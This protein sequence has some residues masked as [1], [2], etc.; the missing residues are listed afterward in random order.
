MVS[1]ATSRQ[2]QRAGRALLAALVSATLAGRAEAQNGMAN[3]AIRQACSADARTACAGVMPGGSR[4]KHCMIDKF[5]QLS[6]G[7]KA[8]LKRVRAQSKSK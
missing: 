8:A 4:L 1:S 2:L 6:D 3:G 7:C 5:D